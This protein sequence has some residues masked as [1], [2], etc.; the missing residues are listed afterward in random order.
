[1]KLMKRLVILV[2]RSQ[3]A[4]NAATPQTFRASPPRPN[5]LIPLTNCWQRVVSPLNTQWFHR[6]PWLRPPLSRDPR[7]SLALSL[8]AS[9]SKLNQAKSKG[10][11]LGGWCG[12][13]DPWAALEWSSTKIKVLGVFVGIGDL[14]G[15][16]W[17]PCIEAVDHVH[18]SCRSRFLSF[19][20]K[21]LVINTVALSWVWY[22]ASLIH[23]PTWVAKELSSLA[24]S[25]FW[26]GKRELVFCSVV[27][28][29]PLCG[30]FSVVNVQYKVWALLGQWVR[31]LVSDD[32][33]S[34]S[35]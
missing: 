24:F 16:N 30:G 17:C 32:R 18:K 1:M 13:T 8:S 15:D 2:A 26:F 20:G 27:I 23:M 35:L 11:W 22:V 9:G 19:R 12:R 28:Q 29:S 34:L 6:P 14:D 7:Q 5:Q 25:F 31:R 33:L 4:W 3:E 10:L 21:A